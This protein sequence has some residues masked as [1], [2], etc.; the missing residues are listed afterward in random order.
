MSRHC[1]IFHGK[2]TMNL[3]HDKKMLNVSHLAMT[4][5]P[6]LAKIIAKVSFNDSLTSISMLFIYQRKAV[7]AQNILV[8]EFLWGPYH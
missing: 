5:L 2:R 7:V 8:V 4:S 1:V 3:R 6:S